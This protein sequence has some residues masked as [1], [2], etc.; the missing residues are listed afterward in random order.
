M[1]VDHHAGVIYL[2]QS[3]LN[4]SIICPERSRFKL[5]KPELSGP[6]DATIMGTAIHY[7]I[8]TILGGGNPDEMVDTVLEHWE[9]LKQQP[10]KVT[11]LD[12]DKAVAQ[13]GG[14]CEAFKTQIMPEVTFGGQV[15]MRF[16]F[17]LGLTIGEYD[18]WCE[19]TM[20]YI[21][22]NGVVWD[23]KTA[24]RPYYM[25]E[26]QS[27]SIQATVY[28][29]AAVDRLMTKYPAEFRY[30]V[31]VRQ[32]KPKAQIGIL[33]RT[34]EHQQWLI[35]NVKPVIQTALVMGTDRNWLMNDTSA[36]CSE[37]WCDYWSM[38]KGAFVSPNGLS[39]P[40]QETPVTLT[41][42][43]SDTV[44]TNYSTKESTNGQ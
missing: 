9:M 42:P 44:S 36:L 12:M 27:Q 13:I 19:G 7:G 26:K 41:E 34:E 38:C 33:R 29:A 16:S 25:K 1:R 35:H 39:L 10:Y 17:P 43:A 6:S 30:G 8:E 40:L 4:D 2:R 18:I 31:M 21:D 15:E 3:W 14:M 22:P 11:N 5:A 32:E 23:W 28:C 24:S 37:K 20:D